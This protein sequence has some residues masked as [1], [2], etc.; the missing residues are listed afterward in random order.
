MKPSFRKPTVAPER[1]TVALLLAAALLPGCKVGD[2]YARPA[3]PESPAFR[4]AGDTASREPKIADDWWKI[5]RDEELNRLEADAATANQDILAAFARMKRALA[6]GDAAEADR[7]PKIDG[8][9]SVTRSRSAGATRT[10]YAAGLG[11][12][13][14]AD[15]WGR[16]GRMEESAAAQA[17]A[18]AADHETM[19]RAVRANVAQTYFN[20][21]GLDTQ[22]AVLAANLE[23]FAKQ[24]S[25]TELQ[26]KAGLAPK[27]A[28]LQAGTLAD[29]TRARLADVRRR[30][31][32][33][34][35]AL[36]VLTGKAPSGLVVSVAPL[37]D[38]VPDTP[39]GLP[40]NLL[41]RRPDVAAAEA[42]LAAADAAVGVAR[43]DYY[44]RFML[45]GSGGVRS[46]TISG[47]DSRDSLVWSV[48]PS[49]SLPIFQGGALDAAL[50]QAK[51]SRDEAVANFRAAVLNAFREVED[52][53]S[54]LRELVEVAKSQELA[55]KSSRE[56]VRLVRIQY[57]RGLTGYL[58]VIDAERTLLDGELAFAQT[59][60]TRLLAAVGLIRALGGGWAAQ[61]PEGS[62]GT[63]VSK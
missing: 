28:L 23:L 59:K 14:E 38:T 25:L 1:S 15:L 62:A 34:E 31:S 35:H 22:S 13:Y 48:M 6:L 4:E 7:W 21:R 11:L 32:A 50:A 2:D 45:T 39:A 5:F 3:L 26:V 44:P 51:A 61:P 19:I 41:A 37:P 16:I 46:A 24:V 58:Q 63:P 10:S 29:S 33:L 20:I 53:L 40:V 60:N 55:V 57:D 47:L 42:R 8:S 43:G 52:G 30:R 27:T 36:A 9:A 17:R 18:S 49:V 54:D 56:T 12:A